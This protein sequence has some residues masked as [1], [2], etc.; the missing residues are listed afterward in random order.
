MK[1]KLDWVHAV[2]YFMRHTTDELEEMNKNPEWELKEQYQR[3]KYN[4]HE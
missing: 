3:Y 1:A 4:S 2:M